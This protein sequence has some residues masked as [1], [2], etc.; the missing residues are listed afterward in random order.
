MTRNKYSEDFKRETVS[1]V[2]D[3]GYSVL[4]A[5]NAVHTSDKNIRR[6]LQ[7]PKYNNKV[8]QSLSTDEKAELI[9]LRKEVKRLHM[10][11]EILKKASAFFAKE[12]K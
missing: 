10:E 5:S 2:V 9:R 4:D 8:R 12:M 11:K 3:Q 7:D 1:L 6:W